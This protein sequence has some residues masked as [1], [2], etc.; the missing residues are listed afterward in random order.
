VAGA[1][2]SLTIE[3]EKTSIGRN[4]DA[5]IF[6]DDVTVVAEP[7]F[8]RAPLRRSL[9]RR[10]RLPERHLCEPPQDRVPPAGRRRRDPDRQVQASATW[11]ADPDGRS[12]TSD[13]QRRP[14]SGTARRLA[15]AQGA[16]DRRRLQDHRPEFD[17]ISISKIRYLEDQKLLTPR[18]TDGGYRLYSQA[19]VERLRTILSCSAT[20][21]LPLRVIRQ[22][23]ASGTSKKKA[24]PTAGA[25]R[26]VASVSGETSRLS[27][28]ELVEQTGARAE[29]I[30]ELDE[31]GV[32][33][34]NLVKT[35]CPPTTRPTARSFAPRRNS[36]ASA[37]AARNLRV[38][39]TSVDREAS[40]LEQVLG[41]S[42][43]SRNPSRRKEA[44]DNLE[45]LAAVVSQLK[46]L[47]LVRDLRRL[48]G[49]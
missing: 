42:L 7:R 6:L 13:T 44:L 32:I 39:R 19:D 10:P 3:D 40:L 36:P 25:L 46:H 18:R 47:L 37:F 26:R 34:S 35:D 15:P 41:P 11:S 20:S 21:F 27:V 28:K 23:L 43:R 16:D 45:N 14:H 24:G 9:H 17:D 8:A 31:Y 38:F 12:H 2:E 4:P 1:G 29:L 5:G 33:K 22:E 49:E 30:G 48:T